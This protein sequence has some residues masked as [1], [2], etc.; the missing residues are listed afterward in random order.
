VAVGFVC[1]YSPAFLDFLDVG[2]TAPVLLPLSAL[3]VVLF[4][5]WRLNRAV[6]EAEFT[7]ADRK[8]GH[9]LLFFVRYV[10]PVMITLILIAGIRDKYFPGLFS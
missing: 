6:I 10:A 8:L 7:D 1:L 4:V 9:F 2:L 3:M 5:G